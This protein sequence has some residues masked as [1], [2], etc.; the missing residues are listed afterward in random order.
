M[1]RSAWCV[2]GGIAVVVLTGCQ[3]VA[4]YPAESGVKP[5]EPAPAAEEKPK[6]AA[7]NAK[8]RAIRPKQRTEEYPGF[9]VW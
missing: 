6:A 7:A 4:G 5:V 1:I 2:L 8:S 9:M 3:T